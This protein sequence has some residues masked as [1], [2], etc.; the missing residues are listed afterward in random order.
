MSRE[1]VDRIGAGEYN[2]VVAVRVFQGF[3]QWIGIQRRRDTDYRKQNYI[4]TQ[5]A[6]WTGKFFSLMGGPCYHD[7]KALQCCHLEIHGFGG[8]K[9]IDHSSQEEILR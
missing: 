3:A 2:P 8:A 7:S 5:R 6:K 1:G 9:N 4:G